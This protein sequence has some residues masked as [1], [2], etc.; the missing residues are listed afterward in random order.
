[1]DYPVRVPAGILS[2][3]A[4]GWWRVF[5]VDASGAILP[6]STASDA[7]RVFVQ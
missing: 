4:P 1:V 2:P 3:T 7:S 6:G 5:A